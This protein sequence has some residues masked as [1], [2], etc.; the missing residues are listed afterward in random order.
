MKKFLLLSSAIVAAGP[1]LAADLPVRAP[2]VAAALPYSWTGCHVGG[3]VGG[4]WDRTT[5]SDPG[6]LAPPFFGGGATVLTQNFANPGQAFSANSQGAFLGGAQAGC[7]Y[8]F[9]SH[10]VI[11][12]GG[13]ISWTNLGSVT[14]DP[15]FGGK[16]GNPVAFSSRTDEIATITGR[17]GYAWDNVLFYG[18][19]GA[20]YAHDKY[21]TSNS[22]GVN[23]AF[24]GCDNGIVG[25]TFVGCNT[26]GSADQWGWTAGAGVEWAFATNWSVMMEFDHYGFDTKTLSMNIINNSVPVIPANLSVRHDIDAIKVGINYRFWSADPVVARY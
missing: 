22:F 13:D 6:T 10:W 4:A 9:D 24:F 7:D 15:F 23:T 11:G 26:A 21:A 14:N 1:A 16:N 12:I 18:K 17:V 19:G 5:Y 20:A 3:H 25:G 8:Q 2:P